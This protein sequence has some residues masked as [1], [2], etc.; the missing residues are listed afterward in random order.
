MRSKPTPLVRM[1]SRAMATRFELVLAGSDELHLRTA[2]G[3]ALAEIEECESRL[4]LFRRDSLLSHIVRS[5]PHGPVRLDQD[6]FELFEL[7]REV[8]RESGGA[9]DPTVAALMRA[10][11]LH[12][13][14]G[15]KPVDLTSARAT[16]GWQAVEL[17]PRT[18]SVRLARAG[19][20]LDLGGVAK[21]H[22][23]D[24]AAR[25]LREEGVEAALLHGGTSTVL[26]LAPPPEREAWTVALGD[27]PA[28]P[29]VQL[30]ERALSV[31]AHDGR[32]SPAGVSHVLDP[33]SA[34][35]VAD[36]ARVAVCAAGAQHGAAQADAWSTAILVSGQMPARPPQTE[37]PLEV[38]VDDG[39][40]AASSW[41]ALS[42]APSFQLPPT[43]QATA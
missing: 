15:C 42:P 39:Q 34:E 20:A 13:V 36:L 3:R 23:L 40:N 33:R 18:C 38:L 5:A 32:L 31:S 21:G 7:C 14:P 9:F 4:S 6:T 24:L 12:Q 29:R 22:A 17:E 16:C 26:A 8:H 19:I 1:A 41:R 2:G 37:Q 10:H 30:A 25:V 11:G 27:G 35:S 43:L 28:A